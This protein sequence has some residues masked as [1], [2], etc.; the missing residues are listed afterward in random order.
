MIEVGQV[1]V[2]T[3]QVV[4][5]DLASAFSIDEGDQF[6]PVLATARLVAL[7]ELTAAR[8][9]RPLLGPGQ[10]SVGVMVEI[11]HTA[12]TPPGAAVEVRATYAGLEGKLHRFT[13]EATDPG[14]SIGTCRHTRAIVDPAKIVD[15]AN[16]R[17]S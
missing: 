13:I 2:L 15:R 16:Q 8:L 10:L 7:M 1:E 6:P 17:R 3:Y 9:L 4:A 14:G 5:G 12:P 11:T